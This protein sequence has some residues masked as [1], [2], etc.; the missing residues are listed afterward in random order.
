MIAQHNPTRRATTPE[1]TSLQARYDFYEKERAILAEQKDGWSIHAIKAKLLH[2][3]YGF[4]MRVNQ[5]NLSQPS[6]RAAREER[7]RRRLDRRDEYGEAHL[8]C[9]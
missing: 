8:R 2:K 5:A 6:R 9:W 4:G 3:W 7:R 1:V